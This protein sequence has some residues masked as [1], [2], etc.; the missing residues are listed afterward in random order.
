MY[1]EKDKLAHIFVSYSI[2]LTLAQVLPLLVVIILTVLVGV[3]K[4]IYDYYYPKIHT[5]DIKDI[6]ADIV[7]V[8]IA[9]VYILLTK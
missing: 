5:A 2:V 7:G 4:E 8:A 6:I 1:L 9:T 3:A